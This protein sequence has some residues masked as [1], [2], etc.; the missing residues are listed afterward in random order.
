[1]VSVTGSVTWISHS[2]SD[3]D[4]HGSQA[5]NGMNS[6]PA[7]TGRKEPQ[8]AVRRLAQRRKQ[9]CHSPSRRRSRA[10]SP[11]SPTGV[12]RRLKVTKRQHMRWSIA[13]GVSSPAGLS[14]RPRQSPGQKKRIPDIPDRIARECRKGESRS[15]YIVSLTVI[16]NLLRDFKTES[17]AKKQHI[18]DIILIPLITQME[19]DLICGWDASNLA[20]PDCPGAGKNVRRIELSLKDYVAI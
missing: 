18:L 2:S 11:A 3:I 17:I 15:D 6:T 10:E 20:A 5:T 19:L 12:K 1:M 14:S 4:T 9:R 13:S 7:A 8:E 16:E